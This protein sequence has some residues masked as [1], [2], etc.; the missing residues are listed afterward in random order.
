LISIIEKLTET[1][2]GK[3]SDKYLVM[4]IVYEN[5]KNDCHPIKSGN[6]YFSEEA[7]LNSGIGDDYQK[8]PDHVMHDSMTLKE[9]IRTNI[10]IFL[11]VSIIF[12]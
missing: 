11:L 4:I 8:M 6:L 9:T 1:L 7:G 3:I 10:S 12:T 5:L 2:P